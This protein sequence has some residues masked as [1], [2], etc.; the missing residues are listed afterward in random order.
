MSEKQYKTAYGEQISVGQFFELN[1]NIYKIDNL[2]VIKWAGLIAVYTDSNGII[3]KQNI[4]D[5]TY[6]KGEKLWK[7]KN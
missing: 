1:G 4:S 5:W 7:K 3:K 6:K 2:Q